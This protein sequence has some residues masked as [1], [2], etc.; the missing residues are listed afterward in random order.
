[1]RSGSLA[2]GWEVAGQANAEIDRKIR[3]HVVMGVL[4][5]AGPIVDGASPVVAL[6]TF[7][8]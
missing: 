4:L 7:V 8:L 2:S 6:L 1:M 3:L 5:P